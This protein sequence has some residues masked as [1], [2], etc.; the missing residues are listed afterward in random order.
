MFKNLTKFIVNQ[1]DPSKELVPVESIADNEHFRPLYLLK[2]KSKPK[3]VFHRAPYYQLTGFTLDDVLLPGEDGKSIESLHQESSQFTLTKVSTDQADGGL[4]ISFDPTN[5]ELKGK[6]SLSKEFSIMPQKKSISLE[7]LEA[8]RREREINMD[9]SFIQQLQRTGIKLY[10]VTEILE[11]SEEAVYK[12]STKADGGF[13]AKF[14]ATLCAQSNRED[15]QSIVI[16]KGCTLAFRTIPLHIRDGA[17][18]KQLPEMTKFSIPEEEEHF[19]KHHLPSELSS[20]CLQIGGGSVSDRNHLGEV[21]NLLKH[22]LDK[23][24]EPFLVDTRVLFP[25]EEEQMLT[26]ALVELS[27]VQLQEDGSVIPRDKPFEAMAALFVALYT[28][29]FLSGSRQAPHGTLHGIPHLIPA[30]PLTGAFTESRLTDKP[31][32]GAF[33]GS[34]LTDK[35]LT[36]PFTGSPLT[37]K[38]LTGPQRRLAR[39]PRRREQLSTRRKHPKVLRRFPKERGERSRSMPEPSERARPKRPKMRAKTYERRRKYPRASRNSTSAA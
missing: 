5:V 37:D 29:N 33:T 28:L 24:K 34:P 15:R 36:E 10:V 38:P 30:R 25:Q 3:T 17:W 22:D 4:S 9:H 18:G 31:L 21:E 35:P 26:I 20:A 16:P 23:G 19:M 32:T 39:A 27:G 8:L 14:Y 11:A 13:M 7:S 12:E 6:A 2:K 1:M